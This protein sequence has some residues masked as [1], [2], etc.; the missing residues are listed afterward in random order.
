MTE[1][2]FPTRTYETDR[3]WK[4]LHSFSGFSFYMWIFV[5][6]QGLINANALQQVVE[7]GSCEPF[8][9]SLVLAFS[10]T[11]STIWL[12][13]FFKSFVS[14]STMF[15]DGRNNFP[16]PDKSTSKSVFLWKHFTLWKRPFEQF[17]QLIVI[18]VSASRGKTCN[19]PL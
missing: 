18:A 16:V 9:E 6:L 8:C 2:L 15:A 13:T 10:C 1:V 14:I 7:S 4:A 11:S 19:Q 3:I 12:A 17:F 5:N